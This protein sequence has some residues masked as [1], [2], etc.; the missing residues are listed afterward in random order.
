[1]ILNL[2]KTKTPVPTEKMLVVLERIRCE[3]GAISEEEYLAATRDFFATS[4]LID[5]YAEELSMPREVYMRNIVSQRA[6][7]STF[8]LSCSN[9]IASWGSGDD[10]YAE[11]WNLLRQ[12]DI[13]GW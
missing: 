1:M 11:D 13:M 2:T 8:L 4:M 10:P 7:A 12:E 9:M 6:L 3:L 5:K